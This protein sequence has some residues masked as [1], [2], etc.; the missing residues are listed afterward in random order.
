MGLRKLLISTVFIFLSLPI[1]A[2]ALFI[3]SSDGSYLPVIATNWKEKDGG[4]IV[5][6]KKN[7]EIKKLKN[8][9]S[10]LFPDIRI[11]V[12]GEN[13]FFSNIKLDTFLTLLSGVETEIAVDNDIFDKIKAKKSNEFKL[14]KSSKKAE[15]IKTGD[16]YIVG[17]VRHV[18]YNGDDGLVKI[19]VKIE[20]RAK[21]G[22]FKRLR[23]VKNL[24][25]FFK[26]RKKVVDSE[27]AE[28]LE[29]S[30][31]L[32]AKPGSVIVFKVESKTE[33]NSYIVSNIYI[34]K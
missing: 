11:E 20:K 2:D 22:K 7:I 4:V 31:A 27:D 3:K 9:I 26:L 16:E 18:E 12:F 29:K 5:T 15:K 10:T 33:D 24:K 1:S 30:S 17:K 13:I 28:N 25:V 23:G 32:F 34:R 14:V 6:I 21:K 19:K 8:K